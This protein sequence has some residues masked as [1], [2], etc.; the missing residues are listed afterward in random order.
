[1]AEE[2]EPI[3]VVK[4]VVEIASDGVLKLLFFNRGKPS[5][6]ESTSGYEMVSDKDLLLTLFYLDQR[7]GS[8][9]MSIEWMDNIHK[10]SKQRSMNVFAPW[11]EDYKSEIRKIVRQL[12]PTDK[13]SR[14]EFTLSFRAAIWG[15]REGLYKAITSHEFKPPR[16]GG[17]IFEYGLVFA[18]EEWFRTET[19]KGLV[20]IVHNQPILPNRYWETGKNKL[21]KG[22]VAICVKGHRVNL[23]SLKPQVQKEYVRSIRAVGK[24]EP[25]IF[26]EVKTNL[27]TSHVNNFVNDE[28]TWLGMRIKPH[29]VFFNK[30][31]G[32]RVEIRLNRNAWFVSSDRPASSLPPSDLSKFFIDVRSQVSRCLKGNQRHDFT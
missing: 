23:D 25:L 24:T 31:G 5:T 6:D 10:A 21:I 7:R 1:M 3:H 13:G 27:E 12:D 11:L 28:E 17:D 22:D 4:P 2:L 32:R 20:E 19:A 18:V 9:V 15:W 30:G 8:A 16:F 29:L 26:V 14:K